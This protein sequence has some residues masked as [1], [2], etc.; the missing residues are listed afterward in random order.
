MLY[1]SGMC[2][3]FEYNNHVRDFCIEFPKQHR[4]HAAFLPIV[5]VHVVFFAATCILLHNE[6]DIHK[7]HPRNANTVKVAKI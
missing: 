2:S 3:V 7:R 6:Q 1:L 4:Q 5:V